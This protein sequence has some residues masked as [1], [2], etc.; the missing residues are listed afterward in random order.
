MNRIIALFFGVVLIVGATIIVAQD[1]PKM[2]EISKEQQADLRAITAEFNEA[3]A[4][5]ETAET[6]L[7]NARLK[8]IL[9]MQNIRIALKVPDEYE[10]DNNS[11]SPTF[12]KFVAPVPRKAETV[13][14]QKK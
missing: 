5:R 13:V 6:K 3:Q 14:P 4:R 1:K 11:Q 8:Y 9:T 2:V 10:F 12:G 7:E